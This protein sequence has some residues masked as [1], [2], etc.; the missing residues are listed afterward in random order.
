MILAAV[1]LCVYSTALTV[2]PAVRLLSWLVDYRW[3]HWIGFGVW[4]VF[5]FLIHAQVAKYAPGR[6]PF[7]F[8]VISLL[9]GWGLLSIWRLDVNMGIRQTIWLGISGV[10]FA[11]GLRIP[12]LLDWLRRYKYVWLT[13]GLILTGLTFLI[14][15]Y[16]GGNGPHLWLGC[17]GIYL[18]P[19]EPLKLLVII[20]LAAYLSDRIPLSFNL[21]HLLTPTLIMVGT[22]LA[23]L[24]FQRDLGT[25]SLFILLYSIILYLAS[26]RKRMLIASI[27]TVL[28]AGIAGYLFFDVVRIRID[29]WLNPWLDPSGRSY[30]IVQSLLAVAAGGLIG[31][32][33]GL[34]S[35]GVVPVAHSD[36]IFASIAEETGL[37]GAYALF[38]LY[39]ILAGRGFRAALRAENNYQRYLAAGITTYIVTQAILIMGGN[40]RL[41]PLTGVTLP[42]ISYGGSSLLTVSL[43]SLILIIISNRAN[44]DEPAPLSRTTP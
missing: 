6:D 11:G 28:A 29:A 30:Q 33:P 31:R 17:C 12:N 25:A 15:I 32:G 35:P 38:G 36:F 23:M 14:G 8:P 42:F 37:I 5:A 3:N 41:L 18:Q 39:G 27:V 1:F 16:P 9:V 22:A 2:S 19:S 10:A 4:L 34:G 44:E 7:L 43:S 21:P 26:Q 13:S 40:L 20:F 24:V